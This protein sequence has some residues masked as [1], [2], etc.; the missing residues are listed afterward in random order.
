MGARKLEEISYPFACEMTL[1]GLKTAKAAAQS[2][3]AS[4]RSRSDDASGFALG[5]Y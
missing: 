1:A 3:F 5:L 2:P 4:G